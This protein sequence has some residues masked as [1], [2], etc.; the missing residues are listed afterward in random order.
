[1]NSDITA[2]LY[3]IK[4]N[5]AEIESGGASTPLLDEVRTDF[6][7]MVELIKLFLISE[8]DSYY[9]YFMMN[10][11]FEA[12]FT[13]NSIAGIRLNSFPPVF[14]SNPLLLCKYSL[15]EILYIFC[16]EIDHIVL[17]HPTEMVKAIQRR[18]QSNISGLTWRQMHR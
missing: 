9:G 11:R 15:K 14:V 2:M 17:N 8:R 7:E 18:I 13:V 3:R 6:L 5:I 12:D 1:M 10:L 4:E 16:H